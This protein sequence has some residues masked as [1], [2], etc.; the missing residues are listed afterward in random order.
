MKNRKPVKQDYR[1]LTTDNVKDF[2]L[3][4]FEEGRK[5]GMKEAFNT[6]MGVSQWREH[7]KKN[8]YEEYFLEE[9]KKEL[10]EKIEKLKSYGNQNPYSPDKGKTVFLVDILNLIN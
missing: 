8:G 5:Q 1:Q 4:V 10:R 7:G 9:Y 2:I 6:P 3:H